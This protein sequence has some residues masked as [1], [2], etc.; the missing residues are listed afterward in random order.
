MGKTCCNV[1]DKFIQSNLQKILS[2]GVIDKT[3]LI[4]AYLQKNLQIGHLKLYYY[5][6]LVTKFYNNV[7]IDNL[8]TTKKE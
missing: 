3:P 5:N 1:F 4:F 7:N 2:N 8:E 6:K